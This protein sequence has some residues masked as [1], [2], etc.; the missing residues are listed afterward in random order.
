MTLRT[1]FWHWLFCTSD[2]TIWA[3]EGWVPRQKHPLMIN[4]VG[5]MAESDEDITPK[6][7]LYARVS[8]TDRGQDPYTQMEILRKSAQIRG[9]DVVGEFVDYASG[10]DANRPQWKEVMDMATHGKIDGI[11]ALRV[12]RVMRSVKHLT[13][14]IE[15]LSACKRASKGKGVS[16]IFNDFDFDPNNP[17][18]KLVFTFLSAIAE[19]ERE[20]ISTRTKEGMQHRI[21]QGQKFGKKVR[22]DIPL[23]KIALMRI[24]GDSWNSIAKTLGIP[25]TTIL[26]RRKQ[27]EDEVEVCRN[28][29]IGVSGL[30]D[31]VGV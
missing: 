15:T 9:F 20:I 2:R 13:S 3:G 11:M 6:V 8:T 4:G 5:R 23:R 27:I 31:E 25:R 19:W 17:N 30:S 12:D 16:L 10:K 22:E 21:S 14:T 28:D 7:V 1:V 29:G 24:R 26:D 18:S